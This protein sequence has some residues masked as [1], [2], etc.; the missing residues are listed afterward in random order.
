MPR[1]VGKQSNSSLYI[2]LSLIFV[3]A[4]AVGMEYFG[5]I[6]LVDGFGNTANLLDSTY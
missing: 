4:V 3:I 2:V 1:L 5:V 6:D